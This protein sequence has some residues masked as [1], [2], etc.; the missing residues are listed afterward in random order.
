MSQENVDFVRQSIRRFAERDFEGLPG[1][2]P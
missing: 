2:Q 1:L